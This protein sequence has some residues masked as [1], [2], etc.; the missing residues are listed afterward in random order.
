MPRPTELLRYGLLSL[1]A[2]FVGT[3]LL[4]PAGFTF[5]ISFWERKGFSLHPAFSFGAYA[6]FFSGARL[7]GLQISLLLAVI[8]AART[9]ARLSGFLLPCLPSQA[10]YQP[11]LV[12]LAFRAIC[13]QYGDSQLCAR[14]HPRP[15]WTS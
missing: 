6:A 4:L 7:Q 5:V 10:T 3:F 14:L 13:D 12:V 11:D 1:P 2:L 8:D 9:A 15:D